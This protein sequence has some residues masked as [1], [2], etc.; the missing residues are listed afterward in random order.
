MIADPDV[1]PNMRLK[2]QE[3]LTELTGIGAKWGQTP[4]SGEDKAKAAREALDQMKELESGE[5][6]TTVA[7]R[8]ECGLHVDDSEADDSA[9]AS[10][11]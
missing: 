3:Q 11:E 7:G 9:E 10:G 6:G 4:G 5:D 8:G 2:A 1:K